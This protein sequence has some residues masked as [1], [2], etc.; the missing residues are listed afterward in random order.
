MST[1]QLLFGLTAA[2]T[3]SLVGLVWFLAARSQGAVKLELELGGKSL[4]RALNE[5]DQARALAA[6]WR[7]SATT[8][9][10]QARALVPSVTGDATVTSQ[11]TQKFVTVQPNSDAKVT[12]TTA[13]GVAF[14]VPQEPDPTFLAELQEK[15]QRQENERL[16]Q[17]LVAAEAVIEI[18][19]KV[20]FLLGLVEPS[21]S[22]Q[23]SDERS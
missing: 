21:Q 12:V 5:R 6:E 2:L 23:P 15:F 20:S 1:E 16:G 7:E 10:S 19:K 11:V 13:D 9:T 18:Q 22:S 4:A 3:L 8:V 14:E 17:R